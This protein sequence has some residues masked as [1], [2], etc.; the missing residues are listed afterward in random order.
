MMP[1]TS[2][3]AGNLL[4]VNLDRAYANDEP[5]QAPPIHHRNIR[6]NGYYH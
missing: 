3:R 5:S 6:G 2:S 1:A 4:T